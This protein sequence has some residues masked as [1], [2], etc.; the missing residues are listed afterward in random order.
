MDRKQK[1]GLLDKVWDLLFPP[2]CPFCGKL[3]EPRTLLC[4]ECQ[5][6]LPWLIGPACKKPVELTQGCVA[7]FRYQDKVRQAIHGYKFRGRSGRAGCFGTLIAQQVSDQKLEFD[8]ITWPPLSGKRLR[9]RGYDQAEL[10]ARRVG[11]VLDAPVVPVLTKS[12]RPAQSGLA[13]P[14]SRRANLL[15]AYTVSDPAKVAG[16]RVLLIDDVVTT[17]STLSECAKMLELAGAERVSCAA[18]ARAGD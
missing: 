11:E 2:K 12:H 8:L 5:R 1:N 17:G 3:I 13:D 14:A 16:K 15:G 4:R 7:V 6:E 18:L 9:Q 10:L